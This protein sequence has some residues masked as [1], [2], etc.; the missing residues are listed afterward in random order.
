MKHG[1]T[2]IPLPDHAAI[3][4]HVELLHALAKGAG[5]DGILTFTRIDAN[6]KTHTE[7][8]AMGNVD[9]MTDAIVGWATHPDL[10]IYAP[11]AIFRKDLPPGAKGREADVRAVLALVGDLDSDMGKK[12]R[13]PGRA[14]IAAAVCRRDIEKQ[15]HA[16]YRSGVHCYRQTQSP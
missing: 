11:Y 7:K 15:H 6:K 5:V 10:N 8:F 12:R 16:V 4:S 2:A 9:H 13:R 14:P 1:A 3:R